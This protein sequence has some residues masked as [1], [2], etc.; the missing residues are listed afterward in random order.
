MNTEL[1]LTVGIIG[2]VLF[3]L[4][5]IFLTIHLFYAQKDGSGESMAVHDGNSDDVEDRTK[6]FQ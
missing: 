4:N 6:V 1:L 2:F 3:I 5:A